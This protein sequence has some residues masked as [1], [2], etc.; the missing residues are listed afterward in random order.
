MGASNF[1]E[2]VD[3]A[4]KVIFG[5]G[6]FFLVGITTVMIWFVVKYRRSKHPKAFQIRENM[7]LE[8]T[9]IIIPLILV[10]LMFYYGYV[11][12]AP[13]RDVPKDAMVVKVYSKMWSWV[14]EYENGKQFDT[15]YVPYNKPVKLLLYSDDVIHS[16][17]VPAFRIKE[18][19]VPGQENYMWFIPT[20]IGEYEILCAEYCGLRHSY[21]ESKVKVLPEDQFQAWLAALPEKSAEHPGLTVLKKNACTGCH[22][23]D[24]SK[25]V[26]SSFK[27]LFGI[28][29]QVES[30]GAIKTITVDEAYIKTA[31]YDPNKE[32]ATGYP[33]GIMQTYQGKVSEEDLSH[34]ID[35]LK[36]IK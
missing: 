20:Q 12:F 31:V 13:M 3:L 21:M 36:S 4:F 19:L 11:A 23:I 8:W 6:I 10:L 14:F 30:D 15:L 32:V 27:G 22:S 18:D 25:L 1:V 9:W 26:G 34:I 7:A 35:Y 17:Y 16:L 28:R 5:I 33:K 29:K 2:G 24:G